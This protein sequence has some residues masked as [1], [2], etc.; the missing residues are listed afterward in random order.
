MGGRYPVNAAAQVD[1]RL[2]AIDAQQFKSW[3]GAGR[4][5]AA[6]GCSPG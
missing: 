1:T 3:L 4:A 5:T 2:V 6:S